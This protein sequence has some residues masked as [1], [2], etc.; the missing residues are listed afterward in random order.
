LSVL[1]VTKIAFENWINEIPFT[2]I[3]SPS[4]YEA[5]SL[6]LDSTLAQETLGWRPQYTQKES[7]KSTIHWWKRVIEQRENPKSVSEG[8]I[9]G[10][11][12]SIKN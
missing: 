8:E 3:E 9:K 10:Y 6:E 1:E 2:I 11:L 4:L 12:E 5:K 7:V